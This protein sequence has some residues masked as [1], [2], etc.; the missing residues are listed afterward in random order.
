MLTVALPLL[1]VATALLAIGT[2]VTSLRRALPQVATLRS[3]LA[4]C[5][6]RR[7]LRYRVIET[8]V[9]VNDGKVVTL[10]VRLR[11]PV[12]ARTSGLRAAA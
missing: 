8:I 3:E 1:F 7:E 12:P 9:Q 10:P 5:T 11:Q 2:I 6:D 4:A